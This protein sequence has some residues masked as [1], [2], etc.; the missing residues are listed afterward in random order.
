MDIIY[1]L[2]VIVFS[3][4][5]LFP[6]DDCIYDFSEM[7]YRVCHAHIGRYG[8]IKSEFNKLLADMIILLAALLL[9]ENTVSYRV[10]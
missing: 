10:A 1:F 4:V 6:F 8:N 5:Q 9:V 2:F 3:C 7:A